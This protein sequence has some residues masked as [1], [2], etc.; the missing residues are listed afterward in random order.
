MG[1]GRYYTPQQFLN[2]ILFTTLIV[3]VTIGFML[4]LY[5]VDKNKYWIRA[6]GSI[7]GI[8]LICSFLSEIAY[9]T[10]NINI[11]NTLSQ[12]SLI[13][14][15]IIGLIFYFKNFFFDK[16]K[17]SLFLIFLTLFFIPTTIYI[18]NAEIRNLVYV[19]FVAH[20]LILSNRFVK[21][22]VSSSI[23]HDVK[24]LILD[25]VFIVGING[26]VI[27]KSDKVSNANIFKNI[28]KININNI[29]NI[30]NIFFE[31]A[32]TRNAFGE[33]FIKI[34]GDQTLYF[35]YHKKKIFDKKNLAG[36]ILT[37]VDITDLI[38]MLDELSLQQEKMSK[39]NVELSRYKEIVY[40][41]EKEKEINSLLSQITE[42]QQKKMLVLKK[43]IEKLNVNDENFI[44]KIENLI[45]KAKSDLND[46]R[47]AVT[48]Y[49]NYYD[50]GGYDD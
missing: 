40:D 50:G 1:D 46:V 43:R 24:K 33:Q 30:E 13:L 31:D 41:I 35:Q 3:I 19:F 36:Y 6:M 5:K 42:N 14:Y 39:M 20:F 21:Y 45:I 17:G 8:S 18:L 7:L 10:V 25:Y 12:V 28:S 48:A 34:R 2:I 26:D 27:F 38:S 49:I 15:I 11:F 9:T 4:C 32:I 22:R 37:F 29:N 44:D 47:H 16:T 23:F